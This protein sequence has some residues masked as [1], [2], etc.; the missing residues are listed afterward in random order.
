MTTFRTKCA[1]I[2]ATRGHTAQLTPWEVWQ[3]T[4]SQVGFSA[5]GNE[6]ELCPKICLK[7]LW[8]R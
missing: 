3:R 5:P 2:S 4:D 6:T 7:K 1:D 8:Y